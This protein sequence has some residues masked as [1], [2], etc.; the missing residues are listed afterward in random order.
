MSN[1]E[2]VNSPFKIA[3]YQILGHLLDVF[4]TAINHKALDTMNNYDKLLMQL[5]PEKIQQL[6]GDL[7]YRLLQIASYVASL[8]DGTALL[9]YRK[10]KGMEL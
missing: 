3:G 7:Y 5:L 8:S 6:E 9:L 10:I 1:S 2:C 4:I